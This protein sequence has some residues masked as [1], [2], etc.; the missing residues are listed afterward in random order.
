M[1]FKY[2]CSY[3]LI[4]NNPW[5]LERTMAESNHWLQK[6]VG[7]H[8]LKYLLSGPLQ[9]KVADPYNQAAMMLVPAPQDPVQDTLSAC[10]SVFLTVK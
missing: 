2:T 5:L 4:H 6:Q 9:R 10:A 3:L 8:S 7:P 1:K